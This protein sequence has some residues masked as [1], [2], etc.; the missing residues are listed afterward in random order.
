MLYINLQKMLRSL[1]FGRNLKKKTPSMTVTQM[2]VLSFFNEQDVVHISEMSTRLGKS[3][4]SINNIVHRLETAGYVTKT[5]NPHNR[6]F[7]D[8]QLTSKGKK[9]I[10]EFRSG[11]ISTLSRIVHHLD[12]EEQK[13]LAD[14]LSE[15]AALLERAAALS[16]H[17][18]PRSSESSAS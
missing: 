5:T 16:A 18:S 8:I 4:A 10:S 14:A 2:Q 13:R 7:S 11:Q 15:A 9:S 1:D 6:R 3:I 17:S 12:P